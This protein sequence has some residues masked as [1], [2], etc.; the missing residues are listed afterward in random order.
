MPL[1]ADKGDRPT[2]PI[3]SISFINNATLS[4]RN[5]KSTATS[6]QASPLIL[7]NQKQAITEEQ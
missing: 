5:L 3:Y 2:T 7:T 1:E 4:V 6:Q